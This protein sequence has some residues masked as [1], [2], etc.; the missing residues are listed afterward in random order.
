MENYKRKII[1]YL[2]SLKHGLGLFDSEFY[3]R[4]FHLISKHNDAYPEHRIYKNFI[5]HYFEIRDKELKQIKKIL[6]YHQLIS[7]VH[8]SNYKLTKKG[9]L[10]LKKH[11]ERS[12]LNFLD[13]WFRLEYNGESIFV[14]PKSPLS[15]TASINP[16]Y[17]T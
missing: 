8:D 14:H 9:E 4:L 16:Y 2:Y 3:D 6:I 15:E 13:E 5:W 10:F 17:F 12:W 11:L 1:L 7:E